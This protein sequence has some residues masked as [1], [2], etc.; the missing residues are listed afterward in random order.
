MQILLYPILIF[1]LALFLLITVPRKTLRIL[2]PYGIVPGGLVDVAFT[3]LFQDLFS[4]VEYQNLWIFNCCGQMFLASLSLGVNR[5]FLSLFL[6]RK[7][8]LKLRLF[9]CQ[10]LF[11]RCL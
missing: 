9:G 10:G 2:L 4:L 3:F 1:V 8:L 11:G 6:A 5:S 7:C